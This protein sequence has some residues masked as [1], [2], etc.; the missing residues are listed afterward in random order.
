[1]AMFAPLAEAAGEGAA[2]AGEGAEGAAGGAGGGMGGGP[3][4]KLL[5]SALQFG[6]HLL[7]GGGG[8]SDPQVLNESPDW[9][10]S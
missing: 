3:G 9:E 4:G 6:G 7:T 1:M 8:G 5:L 10:R 2:A